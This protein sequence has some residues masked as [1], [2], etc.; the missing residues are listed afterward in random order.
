MG[1]SCRRRLDDALSLSE[2]PAVPAGLATAVRDVIGDPWLRSTLAPF[3][4]AGARR[5][6]AGEALVLSLLE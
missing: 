4:L 1:G 6:E 3:G 2:N 5:V